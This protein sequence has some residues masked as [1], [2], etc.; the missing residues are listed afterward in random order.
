MRLCANSSTHSFTLQSPVQPLLFVLEHQRGPLQFQ[1]HVPL[2]TSHSTTTLATTWPALLHRE[3]TPA[4]LS[5][6]GLWTWPA[7]T[8]DCNP[9]RTTNGPC[10]TCLLP[11][12]CLFV[13]LAWLL[14]HSVHPTPPA[15]CQRCFCG[16]SAWPVA[17][18]G[19]WCLVLG[20]VTAALPTLCLGLRHDMWHCC[21]SSST[22]SSCLSM[23]RSHSVEQCMPSANSSVPPVGTFAVLALLP[24]PL[25]GWC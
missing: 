25:G 1:S 22:T 20:C 19:V 8:F 11:T 12:Q 7:G 5:P 24:L 17:C 13:L 10:V 16:C 21:C 18:V 14:C 23:P 2:P 6:F 3:C 9:N 15:P 4:R